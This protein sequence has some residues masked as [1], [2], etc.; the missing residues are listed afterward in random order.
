MK[1]D[2]RVTSIPGTYSKTGLFSLSYI[3]AVEEEMYFEVSRGAVNSRS[4]KLGCKDKK[5][6]R[7]RLT[8]RV[9][10]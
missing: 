1:G 2:S 4:D 8:I 5:M 6:A 7:D 9:L 10:I 3:C